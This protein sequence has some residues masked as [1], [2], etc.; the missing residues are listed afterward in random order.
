M[1]TIPTL[2]ENQRISQG[3]VSGFQDTSIARSAGDNLSLLGKTIA[4]ASEDL[5]VT[6]KEDTFSRSQWVQRSQAEAERAKNRFLSTRKDAPKNDDGSKLEEEYDTYS[7]DI[8]NSYLDSVPEDFRAEA[9]MAYDTARLKGSADVLKESEI[10]RKTNAVYTFQTTTNELLNEVQENPSK[11]KE[12]AQKGIDNIIVATQ[13]GLL[14]AEKMEDNIRGFSKK[15]AQSEIDGYLKIPQNSMD[16]EYFEEA[17]K[18]LERNKSLFTPEEY[19]KISSGI[20]TAKYTGIERIIKRENDAAKTRMEANKQKQE[21]EI[22]NS[23]QQLIENKNNPTKVQAIKETLKDRFKDGKYKYAA[24]AFFKA[25][26]Q[27][28]DIQDAAMSYEIARDLGNKP[29]NKQ[30]NDMRDRIRYSVANDQIGVE[31]G[32]YWLKRL[33]EFNEANKKDPNHGQKVKSIYSYIKLVH[34]VSDIENMTDISGENKRSALAAIYQAETLLGKGVSPE[35]V[36]ASLKTKFGQ[37]KEVIDI[38]SNFPLSPETNRALDTLQAIDEEE[39]DIEELRSRGMIS[40]QEYRNRMQKTMRYRQSIE[41]KKTL[42]ERGLDKFIN[43]LQS[44]PI[45][46]QP[47]QIPL[48]RQ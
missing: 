9:E 1:P 35:Y 41:A 11:T 43:E 36:L 16:V 38:P 17:K 19:S 13:S 42:Q 23:F 7:T 39:K 29:S 32:E 8:K 18:A 37:T 47:T 46:V 20:D 30:I 40:T 34:N 21:E 3:G 4:K 25:F 6:R 2:R 12:I 28:D 48:R 24:P 26:K 45:P 14:P 22:N 33:N 5:K 10:R 44:N 31:K 27:A 15:A